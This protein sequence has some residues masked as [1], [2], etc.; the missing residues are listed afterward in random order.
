MSYSAPPPWR[1]RLLDLRRDLV[2]EFARGRRIIQVGWGEREVTVEWSS[3]PGW[4]REIHRSGNL[5][6]DI[7]LLDR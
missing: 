5:W 6:R 1:G 7:E 3:V 2:V 4:L